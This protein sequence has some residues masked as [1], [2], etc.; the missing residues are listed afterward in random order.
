MHQEPGA[1]LAGTVTLVMTEGRRVIRLVRELSPPIFGALINEYQRLLRDV[2]ERMGGRQ[3]EVV[4][5]TAIAAFPTAKQA[6][7]AAAVVQHVV[8]THEWPH[9]RDVA[10]SVGVHSGEVGIGWLG[11]ATIRCEALCDA[12]EGGQIFLSPSTAALLEEEDLG[13][14]VIRDLGE[15]A[16]RRS[17]S[18]ARAFE[19]LSAVPGDASGSTAPE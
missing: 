3:F 16:T 17:G 10:I 6:A 12:A 8:A 19:L 11:A 5:D 4:Q 7:F 9:K 18:R 14:L 2:M 13:D 1:P 15:P